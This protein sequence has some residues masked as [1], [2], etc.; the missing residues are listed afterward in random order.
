MRES[1]RRAGSLSGDDKLMVQTGRGRR[2]GVPAM[3][4]TLG[5]SDLELLRKDF[6]A[7]PAYRLAQNAVTRTALYDVAISRGGFNNSDHSRAGML[8]GWKGTNKE[9][10]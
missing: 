1:I 8:G 7:N 3:N 6:A 5:A 2:R 10:S 4:G 9:H